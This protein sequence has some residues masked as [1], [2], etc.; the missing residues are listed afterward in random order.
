MFAPSDFDQFT[1]ALAA[2]WD[3]IFKSLHLV[4]CSVTLALA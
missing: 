4:T 2:L 1:L 3:S